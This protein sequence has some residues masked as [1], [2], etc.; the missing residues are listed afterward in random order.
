MPVAWLL[1]VLIGV[2][3]GSEADIITY[4]VNRY[5]GPASYIKDVSAVFIPFATGEFRLQLLT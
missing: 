1:A 4:M 2:G 5:F 3:L